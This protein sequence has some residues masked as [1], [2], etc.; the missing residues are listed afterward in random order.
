MQYEPNLWGS[1][2]CPQC[3]K[4]FL[5]DCGVDFCSS[6]CETEYEKENCECE[7]CDDKYHEDDLIKGVCEN[8]L[9]EM[10]EEK[11]EHIG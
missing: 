6:S 9:D 4:R 2:S 1:V 3:G 10:E 7:Q 11:H 5:S 8:C